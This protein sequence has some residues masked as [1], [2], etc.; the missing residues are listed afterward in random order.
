MNVCE[1]L[2][3]SARVM[4]SVHYEAPSEMI[5]RTIIIH[6]MNNG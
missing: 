5:A 3:C 6:H 4:F 2:S 1:N